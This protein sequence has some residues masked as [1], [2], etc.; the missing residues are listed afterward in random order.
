MRLLES[1]YRESLAAVTERLFDLA[2]LV[3]GW[4]VL[5]IGTGAGDTA[6][7]A[8]ECV[9]PSGFVLATDASETTIEGLA[10]RL[11]SL[12]EPFP[13]ATAPVAME[14]L[15]LESG[16]FDVALARNSVM[17]FTEPQRALGNVRAALRTGGRF[18]A[19]VYGPIERDPFHAV[20][21][22]AV[23]RRCE[24][25]EPLPEYVQAFR[26]GA[27]EIERAL[28]AAG[29]R[30]VQRHVVPTHRTFPSLPEAMEALRFSGSLARLLA[31]LPPEH[32][33]DAWG[34]IASG[35]RKHLSETGL[36][37]PGEQ[38]VLVGMA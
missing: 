35:F 7:I 19:S 5:D 17:Y 28:I 4:R 32:R 37:L 8:A 34:D 33:E 25:R 22:A 10:L 23:R 11:R 26:V 2:D 15:A 9:G 30:D 20:P 12:P 14:S 38:V 31:V 18:V 16:S 36:R 27:D 13:I 6:L 24:I 3:T 1:Q 29:F 21:V